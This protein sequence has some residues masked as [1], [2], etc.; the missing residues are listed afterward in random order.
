MEDSYLSRNT[1][2]SEPGSV[3]GLGKYYA[4]DTVMKGPKPAKPNGRDISPPV[5][6]T[7]VKSIFNRYS[8]FFVNQLESGARKHEPII[9]S[10][11]NYYSSNSGLRELSI[12]RRTTEQN[13]LK[14]RKYPTAS[15]IIEWCKSGNNNAVEYSW[16][17]FLWCKR[18]GQIPNNY[19]V[20]LRRFTIP[21][22]DDLFDPQKNMN[23]DI[24]RM[25]TWVDGET[26]KWENVGL[27]WSQGLK[28]K[29][30]TAEIQKVNA[31]E[32]TP[33]S[34]VGLLPKVAQQIVG[35]TDRNASR[36]A[37]RN[38]N[39]TGFDP[40]QDKNKV[41]EPIDIINKTHIRDSGL[42]FEQDINLVFEYELR[43]IDGVN[44]RAAMIDLLSNIGIVTMNRGSFWGGDVRFYGANPRRLSPLGDSDKFHKD[45]DFMSYFKSLGSGIIDRLSGLAGG[46]GF[47]M[48]G[49]SSAAKGIAGNLASQLAGG[50]LD[51]MGRPGIVVINSLL[52]GQS[53]GQWHLTVGNPANPIISIGNLI[54][55]KTE[56]EVFGALGYD[57]FPTN[58]KVTCKL[59]PAR[60]RDRTEIMSM[61]SRNH[62]TYLTSPPEATKFK[63]GDPLGQN[64]KRTGK[65][66]IKSI[67]GIK[68]N[69]SQGS[70]NDFI[71]KTID[72]IET[73]GK[74]ESDLIKERWPSYKNKVSTIINTAKEIF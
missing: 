70:T 46:K 31:S 58:V 69:L 52:T 44:P 62:R 37:L 33:G 1:S 3:Q 40:Y 55:D 18:Y 22:E 28:W 26:N 73:Y 9:D 43:S 32:V 29:E 34:D 2:R 54:L 59:K 14:V 23:P 19:M 48:E 65:N 42:E 10:P 56:I 15:N 7:A 6:R 36:G 13:L 12:G 35:L 11:D 45:G 5:D 66:Q 53:I 21:V 57:D 72:D 63:K 39:E 51:K 4:T 30:L 61:F 64:K 71:A 27:K 25:I 17:D 20:T 50:A 68:G 16:E 38:P 74:D 8:V 47:S 24:A 60:P 67:N 41:Y 49:I